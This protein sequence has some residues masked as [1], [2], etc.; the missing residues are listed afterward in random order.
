MSAP[1]IFVRD[2]RTLPFV[3]VSLAAL[4]RIRERC[5]KRPYAVATY[6]A[7]LELANEDRMDRVAV[8]QKLLAER[9]GAG[10]TTVQG[11]L[12]ELQGAGL[13]VV[14][15][16]IHGGQRLENEYVVV[17]PSDESGTPARET[18]DPRPPREQLS[19]EEEKKSPPD[20]NGTR[21]GAPE[22]EFP[23]DLPAEMHETA[24]AV[25]KLLTRTALAREQKR[26]VTRAAVGHAVLTFPD[27]DHITVARNLESWL[28]HGR[29]TKQSCADVVARYR[30]FLETSDPVAGPPL[31]GGGPQASGGVATIDDMK[32]MAADLR[33]R[34]L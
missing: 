9:V 13:V 12:A 16:R 4:K 26:K 11:A 2:G 22:D 14:H 28:L 32:R 24:I 7:L 20:R 23:E 10:R 17:E 8:T 33:E 6:M 1:L 30:R 21:V 3:P 29:G 18:G 5:E 27:R 34:G 31:A 25:G 19:P 15:E